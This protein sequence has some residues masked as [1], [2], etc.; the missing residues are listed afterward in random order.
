[1]R[2]QRG[3]SVG[4]YTILD[5]IATGGMGEVHRARD[6]QLDRIVA[7]KAVAAGFLHDRSASPRFQRERDIAVKLEHPHICRLLDAGH[8]AGVD[9]FVLEYLTG[10]TLAARVRRGPVPVLEAIELGVDIAGALDYAHRQG[11]IHRDLKPANVMLTATGAKVL[12][13]GI[14]SLR[15]VAPSAS[16]VNSD[17]APLDAKQAG[18]ILGTA[19]YLAPERLDDGHSDHRTDVFG[20]GLVLYEMLTGRRPFEGERPA[21][22]VAKVLSGEPPPMALTVAHGD[23]LEW[24]VRKC[25]ARKPDDRWQSIADVAT[26]LKGIAARAAIP[27]VERRRANLRLRAA[28]VAVAALL[29]LSVFLSV[30]AAS[31]TGPSAA[32]ARPAVA[33]TVAPPAGG[34]FTPT[35][36]SVQTPQFAVSPTGD[37]LAFVATGVDGLSQL[38]LRS[39][40]AL[41]PK[42]IA[43]TA[44]AMYPFWSPDGRSIGFFAHGQLKRV[45]LS[46]GPPRVLAATPNGRGGSWNGEGIILFSSTTTGVIYSVPAGGGEPKAQTQLRAERGETSHRWPHFLPDGRRFLYFAR[47]EQPAHEGIYLASLDDAEDSLVANSNFGGMYVAPGWVLFLSEGTLLARAVDLDQRRSLGEPV[48]VAEHVAGSSSFYPAFSVS[49]AGVIAY[50]RTGDS[51]ELRWVDRTGNAAAV[52][53]PQGRYVD[54]RL[55][56]DDR[57]LAIS[58]VEG[59]TDRSDIYILDFVRGTRDR[60]TSARATDASVTW[61]PDGTRLAFRSNRERI[62]D[63]YVRT[64]ATVAPEQVF[65]RSPNAKYPTSW[66]PDGQLLVYQTINADSGIDLWAA[67]IASPDKSFPLVKTAFD[68]TQGQ[69]SPDGRW[70]AYTSNETGSS[71]VYVQAIGSTNP[72]WQVSVNRGGADPKWRRDGSELYYVSADDELIAV[73]VKTGGRLELGKPQALFPIPHAALFP[74][75]NYDVSA[76]GRFLVRAQLDD[77]RTIPL[78]VLAGWSP[79]VR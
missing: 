43:G 45:E 58:E 46:G 59:D 1:V 72:R 47:S 55:S 70:L 40:D 65:L 21:A 10:E 32:V 51:A 13:F 17:T 5:L 14:A 62:H 30:F 38:W 33:F 19:A 52:A 8:D 26:V 48:V 23:E 24:L 44:E 71:Q 76:D 73:P 49:P 31:R 4:R 11:V 68:E 27:R 3:A 79:P 18:A 75:T 15:R 2:F 57:L 9:Y 41:V 78:T 34:M 56:P 50:A 66:S 42:S 22:V 69:V 67:P 77:V 64:L 39:L 60:M 12:D 16:M 74:Y 7:I 6:T 36:A 25:L 37:Q 53:V 28:M 61:S 54:F 35:D 20:F 63:L 29:I